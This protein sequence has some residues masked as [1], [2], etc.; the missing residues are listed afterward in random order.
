MFEV[1]LGETGAFGDVS[2]GGGAGLGLMERK[3]EEGTTCI[4]TP[5][6]NA[7]DLIVG[8]RSA[9]VVDALSSLD[10]LD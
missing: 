4:V 1:G 3:A 2:Y 5:S 8:L 7:H 9:C 10:V 6:R